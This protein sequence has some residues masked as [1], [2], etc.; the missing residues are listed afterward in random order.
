[1]FLLRDSDMR[2]DLQQ[3]VKTTSSYARENPSDV[4]KLT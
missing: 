2:L 4:L 1:M 3:N